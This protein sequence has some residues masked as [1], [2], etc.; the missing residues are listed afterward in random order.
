MEHLSAE[1]KACLMYLEETIE[2]LDL[3][4]DSGFSND[5]PDPANLRRKHG[6]SES[7]PEPSNILSM[8]AQSRS[9][10]TE[11]SSELDNPDVQ[12]SGSDSDSDSD[13]PSHIPPDP[14]RARPESTSG[15]TTPVPEHSTELSL[16]ADREPQSSLGETE[17]SAK[18]SS[19][20]DMP[21]I[22]PPSDFM[23][24]PNSSSSPQTH[25]AVSSPAPRPTIDLEVLRRRAAAKSSPM[26]PPLSPL[27]PVPV[28]SAP[29]NPSPISPSSANPSPI[30]PI[31]PS[32][33]SPSTT[34]PSPTSPSLASPSLTSPSTTF[35]IFASQEKLAAELSSPL[36]S[37]PSSPQTI[38]PP[39][40]AEPKS[41]PA[42][43][44]K[45]KRLP[46][47]II[48]K[49]HK[50]AGGH[51]SSM[52]HLSPSMSGPAM[53]PQKVRME[54]LRKLG[55]LKSDE[56]DS[57][58][59][60][61][62][63][64]TRRSWASS[65]VSPPPLKSAPPSVPSAHTPVQTPSSPCHV[66]SEPLPDIIPVP[67][68][69]SDDGFMEVSGSSLLEKKLSSLS[70]GVKSATLERS[71]LGLSSYIESLEQ[72]KQTLG[73]LRNS[74][75]RPA[76]LG[77]GKDFSSAGGMASTEAGCG[78]PAPSSS[79]PSDNSQKLPRSQGISVLICPRGQSEES[80][81]AALK[82]LGLLRD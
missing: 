25:S 64:Q 68:A 20:T 55:L 36:S 5:E 81:R 74:R 49:S 9:G 26:S 47:N 19:E 46:P 12:S 33:A 1:E 32:L 31:S 66:P 7:V 14:I 29:I 13:V 43:A 80:R 2:S 57:G 11:A 41:P 51:E 23:D 63:L 15:S 56:Y 71:G 60:T 54:A 59:A 65:P 37:D 77:S 27:S 78:R 39:G 28:N 67:A 58:P 16:S 73:Q 50:S 70:G 82:K 69:F 76:S 17:L 44:P 42:V 79:Q 4:E 38:A 3:Q 61:K 18:P 35:P 6:G 62:P 21:F 10:K 52:G 24:E 40:P 22:P 75:P 45:P 34:F 8:L 30:S 53:D 72:D 48:L